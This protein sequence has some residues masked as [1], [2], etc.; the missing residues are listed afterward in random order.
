MLARPFKLALP[1]LVAALSIA[2]ARKF[3]PRIKCS[4]SEP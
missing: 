2:F 3:M 4:R 1:V